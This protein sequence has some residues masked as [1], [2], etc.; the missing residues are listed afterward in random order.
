MIKHFINIS[1][2]T[3]PIMSLLYLRRQ[4]DTSLYFCRPFGRFKGVV[5]LRHYIIV[6]YKHYHCLRSN[7]TMY[8]SL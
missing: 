6:I 1:A 2:L 5:F 3:K 7:N 4:V 8:R